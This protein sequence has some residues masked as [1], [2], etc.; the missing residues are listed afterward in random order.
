MDLRSAAA[1]DAILEGLTEPQR[2]AVAHV[3]GPLLVVAGAGSGKTRVITRRV[4]WLLA[5]GTPPWAILAIT[6]TNKA[7]GEMK[8][9][10]G[11]AIGRQI[12][13]FGSLAHRF[14]TICTFHSLCLR[15]LKQYAVRLGLEPNFTIYDTSDQQKVLKLAVKECGMDEKQ[16]TLSSLHH[17]ISNAKN[18]LIGPESF[19]G[20]AG[21]FVDREVAKV[22]A[23]YQKLLERNSALDFDDLLYRTAIAFKTHPDILQELQERFEYVLI[24]EYQDTNHAQ[25]IIAH[26]LAMKHKNICVVGDPDQSI[27]A[28]RGA[29]MRNI[30][31]FERDYPEAKVVR[32]EQNY[33]SSKRI[34]RIASQLIAHNRERKKKDLWTENDEGPK[35]QQ[36]ICYDDREEAQVIAESLRQLHTGQNI[37][38]NQMAIFYRINAMS[39]SMED[40][41]RRAGVPYQIA[42][43]VEFYNRAEIKD[44]LAYLKVIANPSDEVSLERIANK[45]ARGLGEQSLRALQA[46]AVA[47]G[48]TLLNAMRQAGSIPGMQ[49]RASGGAVRLAKLFEDWNRMAFGRP[50]AG[51]TLLPAAAPE[52][53]EVSV[54]AILEA[55]VKQSGMEESFGRKEGDIEGSEMDNINE[56]ISSAAQ[57]DEEN[58]QADLR[59]YLDQVSLISD[60]DHMGEAGAVTLMT[61]HAAKGLEFPVVAIIG[62][63]NGVLPHQRAFTDQAQM[64]EERRLCF[65]GITRAQQLL[66]LTRAKRRLVRGQVEDTVPSPFLSEMPKSEMET[67][68]FS[69]GDSFSSSRG[70][71]EPQQGGRSRWDEDSQEQPAAAASIY[72]PGQRVK[73]PKFGPG[74]VL[75]ASPMG[76]ETRLVVQFDVAGRKTLIASF[77]RLQVIG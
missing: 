36:Y 1:Q 26:A 49:K 18:K 11:T 12:R 14:P 6:F 32:L 25:Y 24:D 3:N 64:E 61:L 21:G 41:L 33:R 15:I 73:H 48:M 39:R 50:G 68:D 22:Y 66:L 72:A 71:G 67:T 57:F 53:T 7:A 29:D 16:F 65:V 47:H 76:G 46:Y 54:Q 13:D 20:L 51:D 56:L 59:A 44:V 28:W 35:A 58:P 31:E 45:P 40:A 52:A 63:E 9:R 60:V 37:A 74:K 69:R 75:E 42:R 19:A 30:M 10:I 38:W 23:K 43:G 34:L 77:A 70:G 17:Q 8:S 55:V 4:A 2:E 27:Y 62:L 5:Q